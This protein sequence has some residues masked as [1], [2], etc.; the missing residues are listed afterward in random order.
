MLGFYEY[1]YETFTRIIEK[2][3]ATGDGSAYGTSLYP[4]VAKHP[5]DCKD[6]ND[7]DSVMTVHQSGYLKN[8][9]HYIFPVR[10]MT[11]VVLN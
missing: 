7:I 3:P 2:T 11:P 9:V 4:K 6:P 10:K 5:N 1:V 8:I